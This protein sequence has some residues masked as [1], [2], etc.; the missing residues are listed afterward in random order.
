MEAR[1]RI[2]LIFRF[3]MVLVYLS[4]GAMILFF[5][6]LPISISKTGRTIIGVVFLLYAVY[7]TYSIYKAFTAE[8]EEE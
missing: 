7:R 3:F 4:L 8:S 6:T 5:D 2:Y 1:E